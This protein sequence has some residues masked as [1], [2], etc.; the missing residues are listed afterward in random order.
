MWTQ[1]TCKKCRC[2]TLSRCSFDEV[3]QITVVSLRRSEGGLNRE[4]KEWDYF[5]T[6][7]KRH[8]L[9]DEMR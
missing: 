5:K 6:N 8:T 3:P 9:R 7:L 4:Q 1:N 2:Q